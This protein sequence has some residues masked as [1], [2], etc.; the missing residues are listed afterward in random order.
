MAKGWTEVEIGAE[1]A[2]AEA[3]TTTAGRTSTTTPVGK[4]PPV[5]AMIAEEGMWFPMWKSEKLITP[6]TSL[7]GHFR[8]FLSLTFY[9]KIT[10]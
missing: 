3:V 6:I 4:N 1:A 2:E 7:C 8:I 10:L 9:V 5:I